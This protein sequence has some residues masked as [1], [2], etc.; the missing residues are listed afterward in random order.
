MLGSFLGGPPGT[1][2]QIPSRRTGNGGK[3]RGPGRSE[4]GD[5]LYTGMDRQTL[6]GTHVDLAIDGYDDSAHA[7]STGFHPPGSTGWSSVRRLRTNEMTAAAM[8][9]T[10]SS[11]LRR[12]MW[13]Q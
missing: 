7:G 1:E 10:M 3:V 12:F 5:G 8:A 6:G 13:A 2:H 4:Q 11:G 9:A